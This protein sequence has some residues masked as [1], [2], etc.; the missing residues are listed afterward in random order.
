MN[1][2]PFFRKAGMAAALLALMPPAFADSGSERFD[3]EMHRLQLDMQRGEIVTESGSGPTRP[4]I[5]L[6]GPIG[7]QEAASERDSGS[8]WFDSYVDQLNR[9]LRQRAAAAELPS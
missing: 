7:G 2:S 1:P 9:Q 3:R 5:G 4:P 6:A 8:R